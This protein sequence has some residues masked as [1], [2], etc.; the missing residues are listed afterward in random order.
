MSAGPYRDAVH[1]PTK[2]RI[3]ADEAIA[4]YDAKMGPLVRLFLPAELRERIERLR[5]ASEDATDDTRV[6]LAASLEEALE[7]AKDRE[8]DLRNLP[9]EHPR[10]PPLHDL[11]GPTGTESAAAPV[12]QKVQ[13]L[14]YGID[15]G[16]EV[17]RTGPRITARFRTQGAPILW[18]IHLGAEIIFKAG[19]DAV[20]FASSSHWMGMRLPEGTP[21]LFIRKEGLADTVLKALHLR[22]EVELD[23]EAFDDTFFVESDDAFVRALSTRNLRDAFVDRALRG[24]FTF[25]LDGSTASLAWKGGLIAGLVTE[26]ALA[27]SI[28]VLVALRA[29][30]GGL[31]L[32]RPE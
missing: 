29:S 8:V 17:T 13:A 10:S 27:P 5:N 7:I 4:S 16:A 11:W 26:A 15:R 20:S 19:G 25:W 32:I 3:E 14:V 12:L 1:A 23:D 31:Q 30:L 18:S 28:D 22:T 9:N 2:R 24:D 6:E 21:E